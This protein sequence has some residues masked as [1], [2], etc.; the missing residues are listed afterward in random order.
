MIGR[1][2]IPGERMSQMSHVKP[3]CRRDAGSVRTSSSW[4]SACCASVVHILTPVTTTSLPSTT[5]RVVS[6]ARSEPAFGS[7]KP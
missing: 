1:I 3:W 4:K 5:P 2:S 7:E 6:D